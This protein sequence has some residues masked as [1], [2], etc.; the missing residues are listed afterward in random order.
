MLPKE[1]ASVAGILQ[2]LDESTV[3][4]KSLLVVNGQAFKRF[5]AK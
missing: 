4:L 5:I 1:K 3:M 2:I